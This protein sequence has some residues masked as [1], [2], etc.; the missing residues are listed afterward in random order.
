MIHELLPKSQ[1]PQIVGDPLLLFLFFTVYHFHL[2]VLYADPPK[3]NS[4]FGFFN[5]SVSTVGN[6]SEEE[7]E[8]VVV[9]TGITPEP[10]FDS[11]LNIIPINSLKK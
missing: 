2:P 4:A 6:G 8:A 11:D 10:Q 1:P 3:M 9:W 7:A 5:V